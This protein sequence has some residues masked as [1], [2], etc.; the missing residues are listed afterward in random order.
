MPS[1]FFSD[2]QINKSDSILYDKG[3]CSEG[4]SFF[5]SDKL[6][7]ATGCD[8][9]KTLSSFFVTLSNFKELSSE[10]SWPQPQER[11][12]CRVRSVIE[13]AAF[14]RN[15][16]NPGLATKAVPFGGRLSGSDSETEYTLRSTASSIVSAPSAPHTKYSA[17]TNSYRIR[18]ILR[19]L[20]HIEHFLRPPVPPGL[21]LFHLL[22]YI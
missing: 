7:K 22:L 10:V 12:R 9:C 4:I 1:I 17:F 16:G 14:L 5:R 2:F 13:A 19:I 6:D 8:A 15:D 11:K 21:Q 18:P 20:L 3:A